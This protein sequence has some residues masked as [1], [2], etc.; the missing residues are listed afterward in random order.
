MGWPDEASPDLTKYY[1]TNFLETGSDILF[2]WVARM[3]M[4]GI[5]LTGKYE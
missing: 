5:E 2:F 1:P 3:V 4:M